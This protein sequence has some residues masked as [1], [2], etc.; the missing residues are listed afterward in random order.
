[1][2]DNGLVGKGGRRPFP[3]TTVPDPAATPAPNVLNR[4]FNPAAPDATWVTDITYLRTG[5]GWLYLVAI[6]DCYSRLVVG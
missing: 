6:V 1:M 3:R 4:D 5:E 2:G